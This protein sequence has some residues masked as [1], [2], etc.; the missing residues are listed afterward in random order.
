MFEIHLK[1]LW[2]NII[3]LTLCPSGCLVFVSGLENIPRRPGSNSCYKCFCYFYTHRQMYYWQS[4]F[5][6]FIQPLS[7][8]H[9]FTRFLYR[10]RYSRGDIITSSISDKSVQQVENVCRNE[11]KDNQYS[12]W[13]FSFCS[14]RTFPLWRY[15]AIVAE[16]G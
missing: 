12:I 7:K 13:Y 5:L 2:H 10:H 4:S 16:N 9:S 11:N 3:I 14:Q 15:L 1:T 6:I 8:Y